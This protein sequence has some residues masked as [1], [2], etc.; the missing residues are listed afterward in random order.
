MTIAHSCR[1]GSVL[2]QTLI[3]CMLLTFISIS[4]TRWVLNRYMGATRTARS[5]Q[6]RGTAG[7]G[8]MWRFAAWNTTLPP[9]QSNVSWPV[10][11]QAMTYTYDSV[12]GK[13]TFTYNEDQ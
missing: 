1:R 10:G 6:A 11:S 7:G 9:S 3:M 4:V 2:L 12:T 13:A 5:T 8:A